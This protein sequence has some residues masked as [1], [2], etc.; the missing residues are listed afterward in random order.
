MPE[1]EYRRG[2]T[3]ETEILD[4]ADEEKCFGRMADGRGVFVWGQVAVGDRVRA[5]IRKVKKS[6][7]DARLLEVLVA[8]PSR[9][10]P[11]CAYFG[12]CGGCKWQHV[13]YEEQLRIK[14]KK[15]ADALVHLGQLQDPPVRD[16]VPA[17][18]VYHYRNKLDFSFADRRYLMPDEMVTKGQDSA[19]RVDFAVG[20]HAP[21][22]YS[23]VIDIDRC[24]IAPEIMNEVLGAVRAV[25]LDQQWTC[26][27]SRTHQGFLR[28]LVLRR[29]ENT[30]QLMVNLVTSPY[31]EEDR[32]APV[33]AS[34][35]STLGDRLTTFVNNISTRQNNSSYGEEE[36]VLYG[37][38]VIS[39]TILGRSFQISANSFFQTNTAQAER[40][41]QLILDVG[42]FAT[43]D[44][45]YDLYCGTGS[46]SIVVA[47]RVQQV[48]GVEC[49]EESVA[50]ARA[51][52]TRNEVENCTFNV[53][54]MKRLDREF[55]PITSVGPPDIIVVDPPRAGMHAKAL[56]GV[57]EL[58]PRAVIYVS[59]NPATFARDAKMMVEAGYELVEVV[60]ID[61][62][63]HTAHVECVSRFELK[64]STAEGV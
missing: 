59:C 1:D 49:V 51:N 29:G 58:R 45:V 28:N 11:A 5:E 48:V 8:S 61:M 7:I 53:L 54:D 38:G 42:Q 43:T 3:I 14:R 62:F 63:P 46:I 47:G 16:T 23:K 34:L 60:P 64:S 6:Y 24:F 39:E 17:G 56:L 15:V 13:G 2:Q 40:L 55:E 50:D 9:V 22:N 41:V 33:L 37:P 25:A 52:A 21:R 36:R 31:P 30:D 32:L 4:A 20:F 19:K 12:V 44:I 35:Q 26:Y 18:K 10:D 27:S 57:I